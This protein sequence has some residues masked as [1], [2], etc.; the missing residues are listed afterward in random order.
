M[1]AFI[2]AALMAATAVAADQQSAPWASTYQP[3]ASRTTVIRNA[4][5][6]TAAG[7]AIERGS[8]LLQNGKVAAVG[9]TVT[10]PSDALVIDAAGKWVTPGVIDTHSHLG[11]Y[12]APGIESL[13]DGN[14]ATSPNTA[15]VWSEH[16]IWPQ[17]PQFDLALAGGVTTLHILPGSANLF[18]GRSVTVKNVNARTAEGM[19]FPGA[20]YG[21]KMACGENP[22]RVYGGK[23]GPSTRM[24]NVAGYRKA[25][26]SAVEYRDRWR[27]WKDAGSD[28]DKRPDRNLQLET[29]AGVLDGE[30]RIQNHCYRADE[31]M[32]MIE[33]AKEFHFKIASFHHAVEAYKIRDV[34]ASNDICAS[35]WADWWGFKLEAYD[36]IRQNI[37]LVHEAGGCAIVHSDSADGIQRLN[38]EAGKAI[39][40][41]AEAGITI[42]RADAVKWLTINPAKALGID[43][44]TGSLEPGKNADVTIWSSDPFSVYAHADQV[45][46]DGAMV[47]DRTDPSKYAPRD[48]MIGLLPEVRR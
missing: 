25:W 3:P 41:G 29:L 4:T 32:T 31:M 11:V 23:G 5:I 39:R 36:G 16:S 12:A 43:K 47:Y 37:A 35:M 28:A 44:L 18:G 17:D 10:A 45:F 19:K 7:P 13:Q 26:Q 27:K 48:F 24:G 8:L 2:L 21:L 33:I 6:L 46:I 40:A 34:L 30:I 20:P 14:E 42:T 22:M 38:Q 1:R 15:E 9:T